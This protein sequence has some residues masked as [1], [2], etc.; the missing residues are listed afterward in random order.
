MAT[1]DEG[2]TQ[3]VVSPQRV[4]AATN[5]LICLQQS[6]WVAHSAGEWASG[7]VEQIEDKT[8]QALVRSAVVDWHAWEQRVQELKEI[9]YRRVEA[10]KQP[11]RVTQG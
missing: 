1:L 7:A 9:M 8:L 4:K 2:E 3:P 5:A 6:V 10:L 11:P